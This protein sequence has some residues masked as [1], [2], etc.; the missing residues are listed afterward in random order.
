MLSFNYTALPF[1]IVIFVVVAKVRKRRMK[2][3]IYGYYRNLNSR[4]LGY[5]KDL[6]QSNY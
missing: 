1:Y 6:S 4:P 5:T 3:H 2:T